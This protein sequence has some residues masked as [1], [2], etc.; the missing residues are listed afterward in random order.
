MVADV[1]GDEGY[2]VRTA[3]NAVGA[4]EAI[5]AEPPD[6]ILLDLRMPGIDGTNMFRILHER[7]LITMPIILMTADNHALQELTAHGVKFILFKPFDLDTLVN[8]V[9]EALRSPYDT[10][11]QGVPVYITEEP[12]LLPEGVHICP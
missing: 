4:L 6:I 3:V 8:C 12:A 10:Q 5:E 7:D 9:A 11:M 2:L 1:L